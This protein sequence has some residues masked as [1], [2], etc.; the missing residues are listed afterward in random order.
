MNSP[1]IL[2][3]LSILQSTDTL[4]LREHIQ[5]KELCSLLSHE[6]KYVVMMHSFVNDVNT[7]T[8]CQINK[9]R[10]QLGLCLEDENQLTQANFEL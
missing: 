8:K 5:L 1:H 10:L 9:K 6:R 2:K 7:E 4:Q 3:C